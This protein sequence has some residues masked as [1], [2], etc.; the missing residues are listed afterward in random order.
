MGV[1]L[2]PHHQTDLASPVTAPNHSV[3]NCIV[4]VL[5]MV[6][7]VAIVIVSIVLITWSMKRRGAR[8]SRLVWREILKLFTQKLEKEKVMLTDG[9]TKVAIVSVQDA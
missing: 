6:N 3:L 9:I 1:L 8:Q 2:N 7:F 5:P 4:T